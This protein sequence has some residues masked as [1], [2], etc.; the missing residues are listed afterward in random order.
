MANSV[1]RPISAGRQFLTGVGMLGRGLALCGRNP[2]LWL[3]GIVPALISSLLLVAAFGALIYFIGDIS[4]AVTW[5][6]DGWP[7]WERDGI[8]LLAGISVI[9]A[10]GL[11]IVVTFTSITLAI[12]EPFYEKISIRVENQLGGGSGAADL[13]FWSEFW[14]GIAESLRMVAL[15]AVFGIPLFFAGFIPAVGQ[16][17]IPI[18]GALIGGWFL[19][20]ELTGTPFTRRGLRLRDRRRL[21][22]NRRPMAVGFGAAVF[23]CFLIPLGAVIIMPAAVAG[24]TLLARRVLEE[25]SA[26]AGAP[27]VAVPPASP[28]AELADGR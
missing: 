21:L 16:T 20:V 8:H 2:G 9:G 18:I 3:L 1:A 15:S 7:S 4:S 24:A 26:S 19:S 23:A 11:L 13:P 28:A 27:T 14:R 17:A 6:A 25:T 22:K 10:T 5:F 12:G